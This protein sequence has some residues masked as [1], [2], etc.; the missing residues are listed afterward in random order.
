M[1]ATFK[2]FMVSPHIFIAQE[3]KIPQ[4]GGLSTYWRDEIENRIEGFGEEIVCIRHMD[5][6][7]DQELRSRV[8][9]GNPRRRRNFQDHGLMSAG[10]ESP[11]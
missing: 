10:K 6:A 11:H 9:M 7:N 8:F 1:K 2:V 4:D 5:S 3:N